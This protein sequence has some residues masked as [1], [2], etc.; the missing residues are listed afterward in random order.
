MRTAALLLL[1]LLGAGLGP[2]SSP[3]EGASLRPEVPSPAA[4][5]PD[6]PPAEAR[7]VRPEGPT[8]VALQAGHWKAAEAPDEQ[9]GLRTNGTRGGGKAEWEVNLAIARQ[10]AALLEEAGYTVEILPTTIPPGYWA[11]LFVSI[12]ADGNANTGVSGY[13]AAAP[14]RDRTGMAREFAA[15]LTETYG[16][17]TGLPLYPTLTR[18]MTSYYAFNSRRY[19]HALH[20]MTVGTI[21]ETGFL[22]SPRDR[23]ILVDAP[24]RA[25]RGIADAVMRFLGPPE[26]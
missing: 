14:R 21:L 17:A 2:L 23:R 3:E 22:T 25:A 9:A 11:D 5:S 16:Q 7:W 1:A 4:T 24:E 19:E 6:E 18:R 13:R 12:H 15:L 26:R 10:T 20:P 8:R